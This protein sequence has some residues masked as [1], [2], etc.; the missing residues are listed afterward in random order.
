MAVSRT[1][2]RS[3]AATED[4]A[5]AMRDANRLLSAENDTCMF[6]TVFYGVLDLANGVLR[7][8]NAWDAA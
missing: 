4:M 6:V 7:W 3:V 1:V 2:L 5:A 8:C